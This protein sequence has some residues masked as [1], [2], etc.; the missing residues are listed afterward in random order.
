MKTIILKTPKDLLRSL[1]LLTVAALIGSMLTAATALAQGTQTIT[2]SSGNGAIGTRDPANQFTQDGGLS[3]QDA[4][5]IARDPRWSLIPGTQY[6][7]K[8]QT[9][10]SDPEPDFTTTRYRAVF[11]LPSGFSNPSL[12]VQVHADNVATIFLNGTQIGQQPFGEIASNFQDPAESFTVN[13]TAL[14][15]TGA[16]TLE[17][18]IRNFHGPTGFDYSA[19]VSYLGPRGVKQSVLDDLRALRAT[20]TDEEARERLDEAIEQL[21]RSL[22]P[23][24]WI[25]QTHLQPRNGEDDFQ[26][27]KRSVQQLIE[28]LGQGAVSEAVLQGFISRIVQADQLLAR[29]AISDATAAG[30]DPRKIAKA[31]NELARGD[32]AVAAGRFASGIEHYRQAWKTISKAGDDDRPEGR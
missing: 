26:Y 19:V 1:G 28:L 20:V 10:L 8:S 16:N 21:A 3:F 5:I 27:E 30:G 22:N 29:V 18:D 32:T 4:F 9:Q 23:A 7:N 17:F 14:F 13:D 15:H 12:T 31:E 6:I 24:L 25:D 2:L 11:V